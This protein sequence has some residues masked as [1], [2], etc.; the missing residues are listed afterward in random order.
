MRICVIGNSHIAALKKAW[1]SG[2]QSE[3]PS[4]ELV[5]FGSHQDSLK[6][7]YLSDGR[8]STRDESVRR[9][10]AMTTGLQDPELTLSSFDCFLLHALVNPNWPLP[11]TLRLDQHAASNGSSPSLGLVQAV[12]AEKLHESVL[13]HMVDTIRSGSDLPIVVSPQPYLSVD[14]LEHPLQGRRYHHMARLDGRE[15]PDFRDEYQSALDGL[16]RKHSLAILPQPTE[17][18]SK[19]YFTAHEFCAGSVRLSKQMDVEHPSDDFAHMNVRYG[20][21]VLRDALKLFRQSARAD[22]LPIL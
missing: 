5:F 22:F 20:A 18:V 7:V 17:T 15:G 4:I 16:A 21:L 14:V 12:V 2:V 13:A 19:R 6:S 9:A 8:L 11:Y 3:T 1:D 10:L